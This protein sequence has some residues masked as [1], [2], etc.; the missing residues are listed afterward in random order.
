MKC[1]HCQFENPEGA[2]FCGK[3]A[4]RLLLVCPQ[5]DFENPPE[6]DFCNECGHR[7]VEEGE[8]E[9]RGSFAEEERK[10]VTVLF[11]D[12]SGYTAMS[13]RLDPEEVRE[14]TN[15][16]FGEIAKVV[17][18]YE[19]FIEKFVGDAVMALF[20]VPQAHEDD[21]VRAIRA[22]REV[23]DLVDDLSPQFEG[24]IGEPLSMHTGINTGLV[25]T[26]QV[27]PER[28]THGVSGD[29]VNVASRLSSLARAGEIVVGP[30]TYRQAEGYFTFESLEPTTVKGKTE[31]IQVHKVVSSKELPS[32]IH[33]L[34]GLRA[35]LIGRKVEMA[36][37]AEAGQRL[38]K[39]KG[40]ICSI[41]GEA[42]TG[43]SRLVEE[44]KAILD[45]REIQWQEGHAYAY[46][47]N[48]PYFPL[49]D[50]LNRG[51]QIEEGDSPEIVKNKIE[52]SIVDLTGKKAN[53]V[54]YIG[55]LYALTYPEIEGVSP[56]FWKA[57]LQEAVQAILGAL[58]QR[59]PTVICLEDIHWADPSSLELVRLILP[60]FKYPVLFL[61]VYR[62]PFTLFT[63]NELRGIGKLYQEI[64]IQDLSS[65]E[66]EDMMESLRTL[67]ILRFRRLYLA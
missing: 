52:S 27:D 19:G 47:Q 26:S 3:C 24:R 8:T 18:K 49:I 48:I 57:R 63:S 10:H 37:L 13:E 39:G 41:C 46:A 5:C 20:G 35:E 66:T 7:L 54:P 36:Q 14:I 60:D 50:L 21:P 33:R 65:S 4:A 43:K 62:P 11:S 56:E 12:L 42:G 15:E 59:A 32:K 45:L 64:R 40:T 6:N 28:G 17:T 9:K 53:L 44:F 25:V 16:V 1:P 31:P 58:A 55:S 51:L 38:T 23:H 2:R 30:D 29:A 61:C 67:T 34:R 22:A